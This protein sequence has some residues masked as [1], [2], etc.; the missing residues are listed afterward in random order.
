MHAFIIGLLTVVLIMALGSNTGGCF[1]P[2]RDLGP[3]LAA[4]ALGYPA[5]EVFTAY[6][7]WWIWGAWVATITGGLTGGL[8]YDL[9]VF[10]GGESPINYSPQRWQGKAN[11]G[12]LNIL[13][14]VR[15]HTRA[16]GLEEAMEKGEVENGDE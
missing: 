3:R 8:L 9:C 6:H 1:N 12:K 5:S 7:N 10:K 14:M 13:Q 15:Q 2:A 11:E 4:M 16:R